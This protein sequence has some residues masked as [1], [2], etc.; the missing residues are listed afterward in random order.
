MSID[1]IK[2]QPKSFFITSL[3]LKS[4]FLAYIRCAEKFLYYKHINKFGKM[5]SLAQPSFIFTNCK[6]LSIE[7]CE[8]FLIY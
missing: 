3:F 7:G 6:C 4:N 1:D 5:V 2:R 8:L